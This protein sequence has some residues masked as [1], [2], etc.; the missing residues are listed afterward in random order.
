MNTAKVYLALNAGGIAEMIGPHWIG[1]DLALADRDQ[2]ID[3][4]DGKRSSRRQSTQGVTLPAGTIHRPS[5][6]ARER[7]CFGHRR[8]RL[9][10]RGSWLYLTQ[11]VQEAC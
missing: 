4:G 2:L 8:K 10:Q 11:L 9:L 6:N 3:L 1:R 5:D 7:L